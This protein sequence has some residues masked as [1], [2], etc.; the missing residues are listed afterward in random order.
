MLVLLLSTLL[1]VPA[2]AITEVEVEAQVSASG[3]ESVT[4]NL[5][6]W[7]LCA[8]GFLKVSQ[9]IDSFMSSLGINV[10]HTG[11]SMLAEA[12]LAARGVTMVAGATGHFFGGKRTSSPSGTSGNSGGSGSSGWFLKGG[13]VG[14]ASR[15]IASD[16]VKTATTATSTANSIKSTVASDIRGS[17]FSGHQWHGAD[18]IQESVQI[19]QAA[20]QSIQQSEQVIAQSDQQAEQ[21]IHHTDTPT[22]TSVTEKSGASTPAIK[23][24]GLGGAIF[25]Q[26]LQSGGKFATDVIGTVAKGDIRSTGSITGALAAQA[27]APYLRC[28]SSGVGGKGPLTFSDV[29]IGGGRITGKVQAPGQKQAVAFSMYH[30]DQYME[31]KEQFKKFHTADGTLWYTQ[32]AQDK[33]E[34]RPYPAGDGSVAYDEKIVKKLPDP[35]RRKDRV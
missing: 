7:F 18:T 19:E 23:K 29:E 5:L 16:A 32:F 13:L 15:K 21:N 10:G 11:G 30:A 22:H 4:G 2:F 20:S 34:R 33:V 24:V 26:S 3:K 8:V 25:A 9:K 14:M 12:M 17:S 1:T 27:V 6:I 31:P 35:P 28:D